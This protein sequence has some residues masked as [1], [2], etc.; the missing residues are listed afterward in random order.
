MT[1][2]ARLAE[3]KTGLEPLYRPADS[4]TLGQT[5]GPDNGNREVMP[6]PWVQK[7]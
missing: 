3:E 1:Q 6:S 2:A 5:R 4:E 7:R